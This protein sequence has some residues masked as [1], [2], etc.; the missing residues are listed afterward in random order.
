MAR[1]NTTKTA[2]VATIT[3]VGT[4]KPREGN[5]Y[6]SKADAKDALRAAA[7][8]AGGK[9]GLVN[10]TDKTFTITREDGATLVTERVVGAPVTLTVPPVTAPAPEV[11]VEVKVEPA[12]EAAVEAAV[13]EGA[14][15]AP[16]PEGKPAAGYL[17]DIREEQKKPR[18]PRAPKAKAKVEAATPVEA[19]PVEVV[20]DAAHTDAI[21]F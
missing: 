18:K 19:A 1:K 3:V 4:V 17:A 6:V 7:K 9:W 14:S 5:G 20:M 13:K 12:V 8:V 2:P 10:V 16:A 15:V 21:G 11:K